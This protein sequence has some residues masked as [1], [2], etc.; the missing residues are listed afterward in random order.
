L[1]KVNTHSSILP[2]CVHRIQSC[3]AAR[4]AGRGGKR[5]ETEQQDHTYVSQNIKGLDTVE[6]LRQ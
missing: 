6:L 5:C 1:E 4:G 3:G 2:Q